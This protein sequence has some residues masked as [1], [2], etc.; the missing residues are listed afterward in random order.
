MT[1][2]L[3]THHAPTVDPALARR[4]VGVAA[5]TGVASLA[6]AGSAAG[7]RGALV[8]LLGTVIGLGNLWML[9][10]LALRLLDPNVEAGKGA[11]VA[12]LLGKSTAL[13]AVVILLLTRPWVHAGSLLA[14]LGSVIAAICV[15]A[16]WETLTPKTSAP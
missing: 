10:R 12:L 2:T 1:E 4:I 14:G 9:A 5:M 6:W 13:F 16:L 15:G 3:P 11:A 7:V 8:S